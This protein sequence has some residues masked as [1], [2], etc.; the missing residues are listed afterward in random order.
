MS[1]T[2]N[3]PSTQISI[4]RVN[5][6]T[7]RDAV[8]RLLEAC[9]PEAASKD[10]F[11]W[12]YLNNPDG[13]ALVWL[14]ETADGET[15]GTSAAFPRRFRVN[16]NTVRALVL[17][18]FAIDRRFRTLG[19][20]VGLLRATLASIDGG[21]FEFAL[22]HPSESMLAVYKR[23]GGIELGRNTRCV[24]L[25]KVS[26]A[27]ERRWGAGVRA[28]VIG[29]LGDF[30]LRTMDRIRRI[31]GDLNVEVYPGVFNDEFDQLG[32]VL[33]ESRA[34]CGDRRSD[35]L[36]WR[37]QSGIRFEYSTLIV[38][39][40]KELLGYAVVQRTDVRSMTIVEFVCRADSTI[41]VA[42][43]NALL[44]VARRSNVESLQASC[45]EGGAWCTILKRLGFAGR[46]QSTGPVVFSPKNAKWADIVTDRDQWWM[47]DGDRDG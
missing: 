33:E 23:L 46:E 41:E 14:A 43:F 26:G 3:M 6:S 2:D 13:V 7:E 44:D 11:N 25:L 30:M 21:S 42:L 28:M 15:V 24:R 1:L 19:P 29:S 10:R 4:R 32:C 36:N 5:P 38:R 34:V 27:T 47:T 22:D 37:Y 9:L 20:A 17:S 35:Y 18:D 8:L 40:E 12:A 45:M 39:S 31:P 16:G